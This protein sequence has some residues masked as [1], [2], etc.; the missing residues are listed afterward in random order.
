MRACVR[1]C[2]AAAGVRARGGSVKKRPTD[3][4]RDAAAAATGVHARACVCARVR[5][6]SPHKRL[7]AEIFREY[8]TLKLIMMKIFI[9]LLLDLLL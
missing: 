1:A 8:L 2:V 9:Y 7:Q 3:G 5:G 4:E 6:L